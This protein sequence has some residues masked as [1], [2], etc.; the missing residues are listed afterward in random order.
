MSTTRPLVEKV[1]WANLHIVAANV[2]EHCENKFV[3][4]ASVCIVQDEG[5]L[6]VSLL[7]HDQ[8]NFL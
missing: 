4:I 6:E 2:Y 3:L 8:G 7:P 1:Y 5:N